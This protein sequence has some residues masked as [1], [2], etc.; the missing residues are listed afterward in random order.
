MALKEN[1]IDFV[2]CNGVQKKFADTFAREAINDTQASITEIENELTPIIPKANGAIQNVVGDETI[3]VEVSAEKEAQLHVNIAAMLKATTIN[4]TID[5]AGN[6]TCQE[7]AQT[8]TVS[9]GIE[10]RTFNM[11]NL[12]I[13]KTMIGKIISAQIYY[14]VEVVHMPTLLFDLNGQNIQLNWNDP[15][16]SY[17]GKYQIQIWTIETE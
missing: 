13:P 16:T 3:N 8:G 12:K 6:W 11:L 7:W 14:W 5:G 2:E 17:E 9:K 4:I 1:E 15:I 10:S